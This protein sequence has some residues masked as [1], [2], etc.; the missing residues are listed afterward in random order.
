MK[1]ILLI[2]TGGTIASADSEN[3]LV[4]AL[5]SE[6]LLSHV[7]EVRSLFFL[8]TGFCDV[9]SSPKVD[10]SSLADFIRMGALPTPTLLSSTGANVRFLPLGVSYFWL[11]VVGDKL[12]GSIGPEDFLILGL[13]ASSG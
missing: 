9:V 13:T 4:P 2:T 6:Q 10:K 7:P 12:H 3:G 11:R 1:H 8:K 5:A